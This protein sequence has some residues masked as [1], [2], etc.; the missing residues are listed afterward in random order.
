MNEEVLKNIIQRHTNAEGKFNLSTALLEQEAMIKD[1]ALRLAGCEE[2]LAFFSE[3]Y[4]RTQRVD[5]LVPEHI[6]KDNGLIL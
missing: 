3:W 5:I 1:M 6:K 4:N 2:A